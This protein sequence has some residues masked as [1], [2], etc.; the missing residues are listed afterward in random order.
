[1]ARGGNTKRNLAPERISQLIRGEQAALQ[2]QAAIGG[3]KP[4]FDAY[5]FAK[6]MRELG[7]SSNQANSIID[8]MKK[9][10]G[11]MYLEAARGLLDETK[12]PEMSKAA[13]T[14][15]TVEAMQTAQANNTQPLTS[16]EAQAEIAASEAAEKAFKDYLEAKQDRAQFESD[17]AAAK[18]RQEAFERFVR[19]QQSANAAA[20]SASTP[21][22]S[23]KAKKNPKASEPKGEEKKEAEQERPWWMSGGSG[24]RFIFGHGGFVMGSGIGK[25]NTAASA[26]GAAALLAKKEA[27]KKKATGGGSPPP[28]APP[29]PAR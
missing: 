1:M 23:K 3:N 13:R 17:E 7:I 6:M 4:V 9:A 11:K 29:A 14:E 2:A 5:R 12:S 15:A 21:A 25:D 18:A 26:A 28:A 27:R 16:A 20:K 10:G 24:P 19:G 8:E 22:E